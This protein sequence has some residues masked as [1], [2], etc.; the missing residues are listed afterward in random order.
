MIDAVGAAVKLS[1]PLAC[2]THESL[3]GKN[4]RSLLGAL[5]S[6]QKR[7]GQAVS[8]LNWRLSAP[9]TSTALARCRK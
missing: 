2:C 7:L 5:A 3:Q 9:A 6:V 1:K 4:Q 8:C